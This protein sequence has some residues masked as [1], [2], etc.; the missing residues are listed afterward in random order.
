MPAHPRNPA[1]FGPFDG[2]FDPFD[3]DDDFGVLITFGRRAIA[4]HE[5]PDQAAT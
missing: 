4:G 2:D 1:V 5:K 3:E